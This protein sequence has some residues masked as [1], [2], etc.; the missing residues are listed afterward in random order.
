ML[1]PFDDESVDKLVLERD[2][3]EKLLEIPTTLSTLANPQPISSFVRPLQ[4][5][6]LD[7]DIDTFN[8][9][10]PLQIRLLRFQ[11]FNQ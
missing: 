2:N 5:G 3:L 1:V 10:P 4:E 9:I 11:M 7:N 6:Q 8:Q